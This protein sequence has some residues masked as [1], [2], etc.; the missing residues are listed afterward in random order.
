MRSAIW[1]LALCLAA[2]VAQAAPDWKEADVV[3][4][5]GKPVIK[6]TVEVDDGCTIRRYKFHESPDMA[7]E[8]RC[9]SA[10]PR[11]N[12]AWG[13]F[14]EKGYERKNAE[15]LELAKRAV[16]HIGGNAAPVIAAVAGLSQRKVRTPSGLEANGSC[17]S[18][19]CVL[20]FTP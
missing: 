19:Q 10:G 15:A 12:V 1:A 17:V 5:V 8:F 7:L 14:P 2:P 9:S 4:A 11:I 16:M 6:K 18:S 13:Q 3:K 20:S